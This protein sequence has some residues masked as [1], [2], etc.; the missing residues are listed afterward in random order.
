MKA[1]LHILHLE[2]QPLDVELIKT[3]LEQDGLVCQVTC[4]KSPVEFEAALAK[5]AFDLIFSDYT[6]PGF[7]GIAAVEIARVK[8][9][10]T[11]VIFV[12][13]T[14]GEEAA[15]ESL[16]R[17]A[18]DYILKDRLARLPTAVRRALQEAAHRIEREQAQEKMA[19]QAA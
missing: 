15:I 14:I 16:K 17:G 10:H 8:A 2:D 18:T 13:G 7:N 9:P 11:P 19:E 6:L 4:V 1:P 12:S 3:M 5:Q